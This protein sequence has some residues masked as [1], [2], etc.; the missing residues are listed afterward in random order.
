MS[1]TQIEFIAGISLF[2]LGVVFEASL[3]PWPRVRDVAIVICVVVGFVLL[4]LSGWKGELGG[5]VH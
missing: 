2:G 4:C 3:K 5:F 1:I